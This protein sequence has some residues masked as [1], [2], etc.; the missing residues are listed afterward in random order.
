MRNLE[1]AP[2]GSL[3]WRFSTA[4]CIAAVTAARSRGWWELVR[5][6][7]SP[8]LLLH[9]VDSDELSDEVA[10]RMCREMP[11]A[12]YVRIADSGHNFHLENPESAAAEIRD[13]EQELRR[14]R[15]H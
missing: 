4:G 10:R 14:P 8:V 2:D 11:G 9:V 6:V 13:F 1:R 3:R 15:R 7:R 5:G 12:R